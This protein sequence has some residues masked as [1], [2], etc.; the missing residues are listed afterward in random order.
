MV[1]NSPLM[2]LFVMIFS[3]NAYS[4]GCLTEPTEEELQ[5][6]LEY[7]EAG[8]YDANVLRNNSPRHVLV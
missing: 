8:L 4:Q 7:K 2:M 3:L 6:M 5:L 1:K